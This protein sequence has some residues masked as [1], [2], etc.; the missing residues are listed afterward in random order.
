MLK[1]AASFVLFL[2]ILVSIES[3]GWVPITATALLVLLHL[4]EISFV[5]KDIL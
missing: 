1:N 3:A 4:K 2:I 5:L